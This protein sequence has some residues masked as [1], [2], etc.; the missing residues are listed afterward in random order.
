MVTGE[1]VGRRERYTA[2]FAQD[3]V[4]SEIGRRELQKLIDR[5][6][7]SS[8]AAFATE[9]G[10]PDDELALRLRELAARAKRG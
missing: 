5:H 4:G 10:G 8:L 3:A 2:D 7:V 9:L 1:K 6:G